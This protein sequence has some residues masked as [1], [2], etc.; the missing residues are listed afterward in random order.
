MRR[1]A[2]ALALAGGCGEPGAAS[3]PG[4]AAPAVD[5]A[6]ACTAG[7]TGNFTETTTTPD[8][9]ATLGDHLEVRA[10][11]ASLDT[12]LVVTLDIP[13]A[14]GDY[15]SQT[16]TA[17]SATATR[18]VTHATCL[19]QAGDQVVP[20]GAFALHLEAIAPPH[21]T[22][23]LDQPVRATAFADCGAPLVE[24]VEVRF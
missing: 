16:G 14:P 18:I 10:T 7:F 5:A 20:H 2:L 11:A 21:G 23:V 17:W 15:A 22:L 8:A 13:G 4:D 24:H 6:V 1:L 19:L 3:G 9:C 12:P